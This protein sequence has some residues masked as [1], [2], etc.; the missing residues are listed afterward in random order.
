MKFG[1]ERVFEGFLFCILDD[2]VFTTIIA[3]KQI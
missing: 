1:K 2:K 3:T